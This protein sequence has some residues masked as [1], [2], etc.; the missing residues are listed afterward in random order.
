MIAEEAA[1]NAAEV[2]LRIVDHRGV[3]AGQAYNCADDVQ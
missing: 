3:S 1:R 2:V